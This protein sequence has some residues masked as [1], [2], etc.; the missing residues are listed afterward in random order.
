MEFFAGAVV[1]VLDI[2]A[3][4]KIFGSSASTGAKV[5]WTLLIVFLPVLG[6]VIWAFAGPKGPW[7]SV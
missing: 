1:V 3:I 6:L 2:W 4:L 5:L 7:Q